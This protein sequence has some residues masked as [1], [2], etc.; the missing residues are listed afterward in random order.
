M[1]KPGVICRCAEGKSH[2]NIET[3]INLGHA[4]I[5]DWVKSYLG[6]R[7]DDNIAPWIC[8]HMNDSRLQLLSLR[9]I[10]VCLKLGGITKHRNEVRI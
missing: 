7:R 4:K 3:R 8:L 6:F 5:I 10:L 1:F 9:A 2:G